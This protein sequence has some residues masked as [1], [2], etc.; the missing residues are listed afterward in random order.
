MLLTKGP[1]GEDAVLVDYSTLRQPDFDQVGAGPRWVGVGPGGCWLLVPEPS[2]FHS[3]AMSSS[4]GLLNSNTLSAHHMPQARAA[5]RS[6]AQQ[7]G[8]TAQQ[9]AAVSPFTVILPP[10]LVAAIMESSADGNGSSSSGGSHELPEPAATAAEAGAAEASASTDARS[11]SSGGDV[12]EQLAELRAG[13]PIWQHPPIL[14]AFPA[15]RGTA[16]A[17]AK[18]IAEGMQ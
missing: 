13:A 6:I 11:G 8:C 18:A 12:A 17:L 16:K 9:A 7:Q 5:C 3:G 14:D 2:A 15:Q 1:T 4:I 10:A